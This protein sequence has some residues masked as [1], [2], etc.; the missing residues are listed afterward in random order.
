MAGKVTWDASPILAA[1][2][3]AAN[4]GVRRGTERVRSVAIEKIN[5]PPKTGRV[6]RRRSIEHQASA[7]GEAPATDTGRLAGGGQ[8]Q[9]NVRTEYDLGRVAG[10]LTFAADHAAALEFGTQRMAPRPF[11]RVSLA[12]SRDFIR[13]AVQEEVAAA[14]AKGSK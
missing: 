4:A 12:E 10:R 14:L 7:P 9:E 6:Y 13:S 1:V 3:A 11:L 5:N 8:Y 2:A